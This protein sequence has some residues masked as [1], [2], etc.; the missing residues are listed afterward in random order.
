MGAKRILKFGAWLGFWNFIFF[1]Q[2]RIRLQPVPHELV[3]HPARR[4]AL[5]ALDDFAGKGVNQHPPRLFR[6][7]AP[8]SQIKNASA[9][10][11]PMV[12]PCVHFTSSA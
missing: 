2:M 12:A 5:H 1:R 3:N 6:T 10:N 8:R 7:D 11:W 4:F 9:F